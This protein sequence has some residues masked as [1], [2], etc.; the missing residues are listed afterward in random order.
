LEIGCARRIGRQIFVESMLATV[1][2]FNELRFETYKV[3]D[4]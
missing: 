1:K 2:L 3:H 4:I